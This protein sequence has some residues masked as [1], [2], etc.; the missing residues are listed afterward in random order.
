MVE[1]KTVS[2]EAFELFSDGENS[3]MVDINSRNTV[4]ESK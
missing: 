3:Y 2:N 4:T 1:T